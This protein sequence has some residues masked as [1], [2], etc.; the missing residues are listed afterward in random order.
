M[1]DRHQPPVD[2][3]H[4]VGFGGL[5]RDVV[6][7]LQPEG[8]VEQPVELFVTAEVG[9][10]VAEEGR[11]LQLAVLEV[12]NKLLLQGFVAGM[13]H[14]IHRRPGLLDHVMKAGGFRPAFGQLAIGNGFGQVVFVLF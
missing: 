2:A 13:L 10:L 6:A 4:I 3:G 5:Q 14:E 8:R 1:Q 12:A 7:V 11:N 9:I